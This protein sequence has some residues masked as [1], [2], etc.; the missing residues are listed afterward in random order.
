MS[1]ANE[2][3]M[4]LIIPA[5]RAGVSKILKKEHSMTQAKIAKIL[6]T[7][8]AAI[9]K[10]L[11][12]RYSKKVKELEKRIVSEGI[13]DKIAANIANGATEKSVSSSLDGIARN[14]AVVRM[15][16]RLSR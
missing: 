14:K 5:A 1:L 11:N 3:A 15:A 12:G 10:Y 8:Q 2:E 7:T 16:L 4:M 13:A 6:G 9:S